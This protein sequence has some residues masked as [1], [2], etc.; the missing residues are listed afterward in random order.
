MVPGYCHG[1]AAAVMAAGVPPGVVGSPSTFY[2]PWQPSW[3]IRPML[4]RGFIP[5]LG[6]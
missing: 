3:W 5:L 1:G 2:K 4:G 6:P